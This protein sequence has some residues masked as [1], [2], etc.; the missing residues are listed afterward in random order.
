MEMRDRLGS[1]IVAMTIGMMWTGLVF[2]GI[3]LAFGWLVESFGREVA[4]VTV[5]ALGGVTLAIV[6]WVA[7]SR[8]TTTIWR[9]ALS[10]AA[11]TQELS[12]SALRSLSSVQRE[13]AKRLRIQEQGRTQIEVSSYRAALADARQEVRREWQ[14]EQRQVQA[15]PAQT[16]AMAA[17]EADESADFR[18]TQ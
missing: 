7:S 12:V 3:W 18:W 8:H 17:D 10:Y 16:W 2:V 6:L 13:D 9:S 4:I 15:A 14:Q 11:D 5:F 1:A